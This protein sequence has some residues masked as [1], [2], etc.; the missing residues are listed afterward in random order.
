MPSRRSQSAPT[1][2]AHRGTLRAAG[3]TNL[4]QVHLGAGTRSRS[5]DSILTFGAGRHGAVTP[6]SAD[7][8]SGYFR[9]Q[10]RCAPGFRPLKMAVNLNLA[11][12]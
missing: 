9:L 12:E 8:S 4:S 5:L 10:P 6:E 1:I 11:P 2:H 3:A 7:Q